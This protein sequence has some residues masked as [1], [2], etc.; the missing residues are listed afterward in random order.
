MPR[1]PSL[2]PEERDWKTVPE[3]ASL[4][5]VTSQTVRDWIERGNIKSEKVNGYNRISNKEVTRYANLRYGDEQ[6]IDVPE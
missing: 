1:K 5:A 2:P 6:L 3:V 4:F